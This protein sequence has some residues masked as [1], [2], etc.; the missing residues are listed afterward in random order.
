MTVLEII[1]AIA[2]V[3]II[4]YCA[5]DLWMQIMDYKAHCDYC[6]SGRHKTHDHDHID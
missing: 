1:G 6:N 2:C 4:W 5:R 3:A